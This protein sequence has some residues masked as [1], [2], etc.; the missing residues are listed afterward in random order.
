MAFPFATE[1][2]G[3]PRLEAAEKLECN[4]DWRMI[5]PWKREEELE[6][7]KQASSN[8]YYY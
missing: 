3:H 8:V 1:K 7:S 6:A 2:F 4:V 5:D